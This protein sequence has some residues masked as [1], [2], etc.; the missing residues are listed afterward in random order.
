MAQ[1]QGI[2]K[3]VSLFSA[4]VI[5]GAVT[6]PYVSYADTYYGIHKIEYTDEFKQ[7]IEDYKNGDTEKYGDKIPSPYDVEGTEIKGNA[8]GISRYASAKYDPR[9]IDKTTPARDQENLGVCWAFAGMTGMESYLMTN[10]YGEYDLSEEHMRWWAK[11][12]ENG[13]NVGDYDGTS[14]LLSMGYFAS[15]EGPKYESDIKYNTHKTRPSNQDSAKTI[16]YTADNIIY[17]ENTTESIKNAIMKYGGVVSGYYDKD[18]YRSEDENSY[19]INVNPGQNHA[20]TIVGWDDNYSK[21]NFTGRAKPSKDGAWLIKNSWGDYNDEDGFMWVSYEDQTLRRESDNYAIKS[22]RKNEGEKIYQ[23]EN[24][25]YAAYGGTSFTVANVF[26]FNG[27]NET[28]EGVTI[29]NESIG[30]EYNIYYAPVVN[31]V[32]QNK[33][34]IKLA[35]GTFKETGYITV[36]VDSTYIP[37]GKGAIVVQMKSNGRNLAAILAEENIAGV[38][39]FEAKASK[40]ESFKLSSS[41]SFQ[42]MN[43]NTSNPMNFAIKAV[44]KSNVSED[45]IIGA[46]RYDTA[47]KTSQK[48]WSSADTA[49]IANGSAIV[50]ALTAT[51]LAESEN[52]PI[53]LTDKTS[54]KDVTKKELQRLGVKKVYL[55]GGSSVLSSSVESQIKS[56]GITTERVYGNNRYETAAAIASEMIESGNEIK[57]AAVVNGMTGLADAISFGA[58]AAEKGMPILLADKNGNL[59]GSEKI[60]SEN[61]IEK[62][63]IIGGTAAVPTS[64]ESKV[65]NPERISGKN[66]S[67]TNAKIIQKFYTSSSLDYAYVVKDGMQASDQLIDGLSVGVL[68]AKN[69]SPIVLAGKS[70]SDEQRSVLSSKTINKVVQVG[71]GQ[72]INAVL[73][74]RNK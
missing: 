37:S 41:G 55:I 48:G 45:D 35:S 56:M 38:D 4:V 58:V 64:V 68:A 62:T 60:L 26:N 24:G 73:E 69:H 23:H 39:W 13:W 33:N 42:D 11:N 30:A 63:Y 19:Y 15:G 44:T 34:M 52:A 46:D 31:G 61:N 65:K 71:G 8:S 21:D 25:G 7:Y 2:K 3:V 28:I 49:V 16:G 70:L 27:T 18:R 67:E 40:G 29:G 9:E 10:G 6:I 43:S 14:N 57:E 47:V 51:P 74:L 72:N 36:P 59:T 32:P 50:D 66:R 17:V 54:L 53:L 12:G 5:A 1:K 20:V 22:L